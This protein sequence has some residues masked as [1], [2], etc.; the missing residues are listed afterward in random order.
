MRRHLIHVG[1]PKAGSTFLQAWFSRHPAFR[2]AEGGIAGYRSVYQMCSRS[3]APFSWHVTSCEGFAAPYDGMDGLGVEGVGDH[4]SVIERIGERQAEVCG[5]LRTLYPGSRI[6]IV[7][8]GF[9]AMIYSGYSQYVRTGGTL[10]LAEVC[11]AHVGRCARGERL[12]LDFDYLIGMYAE[13][14]GGENVIVLP[15]ELLR[16]DRHRFLAV[17][18][19]R[20][21]VEHAETDVGRVNPSL[22]P[23][24]LYWYPRI[25]R[26]LVEGTARAGQ[27]PARRVERWYLPRALDNRL[28]PLVRLLARARPGRAVTA[29][30]VPRE[31][32]RCYQGKAASL[33]QDPLY[34]PYAADYLWEEGAGAGS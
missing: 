10:S 15:Y 25:S 9:R 2:Y 31:L 19:A 14:F 34:A 18:E 33:R 21:G 3:D 28:R 29:A 20:L 24:E 27:G 11:A 30:Q 6:L 7:T 23:E 13:A 4:E 32:L 17:L 22:S 1:Y 16:D 8:R 26:A 12:H 5:T